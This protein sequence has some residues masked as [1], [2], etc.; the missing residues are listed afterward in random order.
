MKTEQINE[1]DKN[2]KAKLKHLG[3]TAQKASNASKERIRPIVAQTYDATENKSGFFNINISIF[4]LLKKCAFAGVGVAILFIAYKLYV[5]KP[6]QYPGPYYPAG[7]IYS[8]GMGVEMGL[9]GG[10][11]GRKYQAPTFKQR[12]LNK[13][14]QHEASP[15]EIVQRGPI[16]E[17]DLNVEIITTK[18][19][20]AESFVQNSFQSVGGYVTR[21]DPCNNCGKRGGLRVYGKV[22][23]NGLDGFRAMIKNFV[24]EDKYYREGMTAQSRTA[25]IIEIEKRIKEVEESIQYLQGAISRENDPQKKAELEKKLADSRAFFVEREQT[26][27]TIEEKVEFV[28]VYLNVTFLPTFFKAS[29]FNDFKLLYLGFNDPSMLDKFKINATRVVVIFLQILS[30]TFWII[31][32][33]IWFW[34]RK[35]KINALLSEMD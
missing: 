23:A 11:G 22:P 3:M 16:L 30:Y 21:M 13:L 20:V 14:G 24:E 32:I 10:I 9:T 8:E 29:S 28:D 34:W 33:A 25:D 15:Y 6:S 26:K 27:K 7:D 1:Q 31:P 5:G 17:K 18:K 4:S 35:R 12:F 19:D 2:L